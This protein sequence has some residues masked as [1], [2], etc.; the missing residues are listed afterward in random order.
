MRVLHSVAHHQRVAEAFAADSTTK[1]VQRHDLT[2]KGIE[3]LWS[4]SGVPSSRL[5]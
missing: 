4:F 3:G 1:G 2:F 5:G